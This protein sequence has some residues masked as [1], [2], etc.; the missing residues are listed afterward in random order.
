MKLVPEGVLD[1]AKVSLYNTFLHTFHETILYAGFVSI[2]I[3]ISSISER[4][5]MNYYE[6]FPRMWYLQ[7]GGVRKSWKE[8]TV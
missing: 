7:H 4:A 1:L 5:N 3:Y 8:H 6:E 2:P